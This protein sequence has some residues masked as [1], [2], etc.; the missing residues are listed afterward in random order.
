MP[1]TALRLVRQGG[2]S[3][4]VPFLGSHIIGCSSEQPWAYCNSSNSKGHVRGLV[5]FAHLWGRF[6]PRIILVVVPHWGSQGYS[7]C[8]RERHQAIRCAHDT[9]LINWDRENGV[10]TKGSS[11]RTDLHNLHILS[12]DSSLQKLARFSFFPSSGD[13]L[14]SLEEFSPNAS[15]TKTRATG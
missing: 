6:R 13:L 7:R 12:S 3:A 15:R 10:I 9:T 8:M 11:D 14:K 5:Q 1:G 2:A 4:P